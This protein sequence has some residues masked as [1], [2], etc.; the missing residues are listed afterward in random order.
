MCVC[1]E[2]V[3]EKKGKRD[4]EDESVYTENKLKC[5]RTGQNK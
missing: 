4:G 3:G 5:V 1:V 2:K